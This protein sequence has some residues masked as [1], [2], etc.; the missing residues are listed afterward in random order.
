MKKLSCSCLILSVSLAAA[1]DGP[2]GYGPL[3]LGIAKEAVEALQAADGVFL[4][5]P[6]KPYVYR[7]G[8]PK[9][10]E[11]K[12]DAM[13]MTPIAPTALESTLTFK[14]GVLTGFSFTFADE[15]QF[16]RAKSQLVEKFGA[17]TVDDKMK[18]EQCIYKGGA[19]F[20]KK[21]GSHTTIWSQ[22]SGSDVIDTKLWQFT[23]DH[24]PGNLRY[25]TPAA[26]I[27]MLMINTKD[28]EAEKARRSK[29]LF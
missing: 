29:N 12:F 10:G 11:D 2:T 17:G 1:A 3:K 18:E 9:P 21:S 22:Q 27:W 14:G 23:I 4:S 8:T 7:A 25:A 13:V 16:A 15:G 26:H 5:S 6:M 20:K 24:C 28:Q 19:N